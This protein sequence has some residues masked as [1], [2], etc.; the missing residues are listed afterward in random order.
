[1]VEQYKSIIEP[2]YGPSF[3]T[4]SDNEPYIVYVFY[5][6]QTNLFKIGITG[7]LKTRVQQ[8]STQSG[9]VVELVISIFLQPGYDE[10]AKYVERFLHNYL[11]PCRV[12][13]EWFRLTKKQLYEIEELFFEI[14]GDDMKWGSGTSME[15]TV[16]YLQV[17][18]N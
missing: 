11:K 6:R 17:P 10:P 18:E 4:C 15:E 5:N 14:Y 12:L 1:M 9:C 7:N 3:V 2:T 8:I 16:K 13:G